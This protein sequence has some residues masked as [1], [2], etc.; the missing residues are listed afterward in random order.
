MPLEQRDPHSKAR[1][2]IPTNRERSLVETQ[3]QLKEGL[4]DVEKMKNELKEMLDKA[5][6]S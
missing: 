2:F 4:A 1:L 6:D 5:K 3:R